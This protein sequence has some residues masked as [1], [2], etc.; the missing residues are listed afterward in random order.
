MANNDYNNGYNNGFN[1]GYNSNYNNGYNNNFNNG[2]NNCYN[3]TYD[4]KDFFHVDPTSTISPESSRPIGGFEIHDDGVGSDTIHCP[5]TAN[6]NGVQVRSVSKEK[7]GIPGHQGVTEV[8]T[9]DQILATIY[10]ESDYIHSGMGASA[11]ND[12]NEVVGRYKNNVLPTSAQGQAFYW[13]DGLVTMISQTICCGDGENATGIN[14][15]GYVTVSKQG[16]RS[17]VWKKSEN[18][19]PGEGRIGLSNIH[20]NYVFPDF[21]DDNN[22]ITGH[23]YSSSDF[24]MHRVHWTPIYVTP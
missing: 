11:I 10:P 2:Y 12:N 16:G 19:I 21:I 20:F 17:Y 23:A 3:S 22:H 1:N 8:F 15:H 9:G 7:Y 5:R 18:S 6:K 4:I 14:N 13:K 24:I